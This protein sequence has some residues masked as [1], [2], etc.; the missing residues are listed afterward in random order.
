LLISQYLSEHKTDPR[1]Q[2]FRKKAGTKDAITQNMSVHEFLQYNHPCPFLNNHSC[3]IYPARP[4]A[5]RCYLS[6]DEGSCKSQYQHPQDR[7]VMAALYDFPLK[8]GRSINEGIRAVLSKSGI[9]TT[10]WLL[11]A[12]IAKT[13][14]DPAVFEKWLSGKDP[15]RIRELTVEEKNYLREYRAIQGSPEDGE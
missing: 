1:L 7:L 12:F 5:C 14:D 3:L 2:E 13:M 10:E 9:I 6:S 4:M 8:A 15:F 11:E